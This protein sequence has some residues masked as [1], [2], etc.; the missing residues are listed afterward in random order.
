[1]H[2]F[3]IRIMIPNNKL[4]HCDELLNITL[5]FFVFSI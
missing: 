3:F 5:K 4:H 1:M 2:R